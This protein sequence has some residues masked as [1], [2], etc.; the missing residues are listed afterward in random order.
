VRRV[1][2]SSVVY[3]EFVSGQWMVVQQLNAEDAR[4]VAHALGN[5]DAAAADLLEAADEI[6]DLNGRDD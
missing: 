2:N 4:E 6:D 5:R 1:R 3:T